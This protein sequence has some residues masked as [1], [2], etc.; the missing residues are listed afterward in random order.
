MNYGKFFRLNIENTCIEEGITIFEYIG[1]TAYDDLTSGKPMSPK[2][3]IT[4]VVNSTSVKFILHYCAFRSKGTTTYEFEIDNILPKS[5]DG[6][7]VV[8]IEETLIELP[9]AGKGSESLTD[10]IKKLYRSQFPRVERN[11]KN[12]DKEEE[13]S[14]S[15]EL[16]KYGNRFVYN[17]LN[18]LFKE[19]RFPHSKVY[20]PSPNNGHYHIHAY[21]ALDCMGSIGGWKTLDVFDRDGRCNG[22]LRKLMLDFMFDLNH[23]DIFQNSSNYHA[24]YTG[25]MANFYFSA[26]LHKSEFYFYRQLLWDEAKDKEV[27][28]L[29]DLYGELSYFETK[30]EG[31]SASVEMDEAIKLYADKKRRAEALW[32][33]DIMS[34]QAEMLFFYDSVEISIWDRTIG[35]I[36]GVKNSSQTQKHSA[37]NKIGSNKQKEW[38]EDPE[39]EMRNVCFL[40]KNKFAVDK[41]VAKKV[42]RICP[43]PENRKTISQWFMRRYD[44]KD[45]YRFHFSDVF[46]IP[47]PCF[48]KISNYIICAVA[49][50]FALLS[51]IPCS[52]IGIQSIY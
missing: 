51:I 49:L 31:S 32:V 5:I 8:H 38:F 10:I 50:I 35:R 36:N 17:R 12:N 20:S 47:V 26:L 27:G 16:A 9:F 15:E 6:L 37:A 2:Y 3:P 13:Q 28:A 44:F 39:T 30:G 48:G 52:T 22:F 43:V 14:S 23:S 18:K 25:L 11:Q 46:G 19:E 4:L 21:S 1:F 41:C 42:S 7:S 45:V 33:N 29:K 40:K 34:P 24:M